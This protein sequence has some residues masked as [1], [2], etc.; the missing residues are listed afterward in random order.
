MTYNKDGRLRKSRNINFPIHVGFNIS[1]E[2]LKEVLR[3]GENENLTK[4][5]AL[6]MLLYRGLEAYKK[7]TEN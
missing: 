5:K 2:N 3:I 6:R 4:C 7:S 1:N